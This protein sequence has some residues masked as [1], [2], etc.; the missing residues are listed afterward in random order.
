MCTRVALQLILGPRLVAPPLAMLIPFPLVL[1]LLNVATVLS[2]LLREVYDVEVLR[3]VG[4]RA[5]GRAGVASWAQ[6]RAPAHSGV[7]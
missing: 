2:D 6:A 5:G 3:R 4:R 1:L 7:F